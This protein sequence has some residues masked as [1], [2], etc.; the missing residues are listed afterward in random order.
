MKTRSLSGHVAVL[1]GI[2]AALVLGVAALIMDH[3]VDREMGQRFDD[4]VLSE[5]HALAA[6]S[7][8]GS[9]GLSVD[10]VGGPSFRLLAGATPAA[11]SIR[12]A[13]GNRVDSKPP[14]QRYPANWMSTAHAE[15]TFADVDDPEQPLRAVWFRYTAA[16][17]AGHAVQASA[18]QQADSRANDCRLVL[19]QSRSE[20]DAILTAID[21]IL[22]ITPMLALLTVLT[23]APMLVGRGLKP[24]AA[25]GDSM[26]DIGPDASSQRLPA[27]G[28]RELEPLV[29]RFNEV[30]ARMD[31][32]MARERQFAG[33]IAHETRTRL[34][35]LRTLVEV[36][37]RYPSDRPVSV[38]LSEI[39][40]IGAGLENTVASLLTLTR[41]D[42][43]L[44]DIQ[45]HSVNLDD[46]ID[47]QLE[48]LART[49]R[50]RNLSVGLER[51]A[52]DTWL[53]ADSSLL[54]IIIGN[55]LG[56][57]SLHASAG[58]VIKVSQY[59]DR[60]TVS[61]HAADIS[62]AELARF[63][64]RFWSKHHGTDGHAG[65][66]LALAGAA[67]AA[68]NFRLSFSMDPTRRLHATLAWP[69]PSETMHVTHDETTG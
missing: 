29:A 19:V 11:Y 4:S 25:L 24:L 63:G 53:I 3:L 2:A 30:L 14:P 68:M 65:L 8:A 54:N 67:A 41:L 26:R 5:A 64:Q 10:E 46:L 50:E 51:L 13:D 45:L 49:L 17:D 38:L 32:G 27:T 48:P 15:P 16:N 69:N 57:A 44:Q 28:T 62:D 1:V 37:Q 12:C 39:G 21:G 31:E 40:D 60:L 58:D 20:L 22:L 56:N 35:E 6:L 52:T 55:L 47:R 61:N 7:E 9:D 34:A 42:A 18:T 66:G 23:L 43:G 33:A 36:E 59:A